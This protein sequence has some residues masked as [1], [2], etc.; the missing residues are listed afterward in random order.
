MKIHH[1]LSHS[2]SISTEISQCSV[3]GC[4]NQIEYYP[5]SKR[6]LI[7]E[8]CL[9]DGKSKFDTD[10]YNKDNYEWGGV[11]EE[12]S[13]VEV[14]VDCFWCGKE[15]TILERHRSERNFCSDSCISSFNSDRMS[16]KS[17]PRY[18]DGNSSGKK[19][20]SKWRKIRSEVIDIDGE[21][22]AVCQSTEDLHGHHIIPV[23]KFEDEEDAHYLENA[24]MLCASCHRNVEYGNIVSPFENISRDLEQHRTENFKYLKN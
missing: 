14:D 1:K 18:V 17:N 11:V 9:E 4:R 10:E 13:A 12:G 3:K 5:S 15:I 6:G 19:Y 8:T 16:G 7:C 2:N 22:C 21:R 20:N 24:V 23:S